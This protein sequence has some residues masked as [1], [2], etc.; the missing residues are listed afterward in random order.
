MFP[1]RFP[2]GVDRARASGELISGGRIEAT[3]HH[4]LQFGTRHGKRE[5]TPAQAQPGA[6]VV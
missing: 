1:R 2:R 3:V 6:A 5:F 4:C